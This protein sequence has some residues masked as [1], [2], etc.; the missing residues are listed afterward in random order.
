MVVGTSFLT[1]F[2]SLLV[3]F[4]MVIFFMLLFQVIGDL[5][6]R[7]DA[8]GGKKALWIIFLVVA[9]YLGLLVYYITNASGMAERQANQARRSQEQ[10]DDYVRTV[11]GSSTD[12]IEKAKQLLDSGAITQAEFDTLKAKALG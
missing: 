12:Q 5:F 7:H 6:R 10:F 8:S 1:I 9:P 11:S 4:F 3:V 2:W